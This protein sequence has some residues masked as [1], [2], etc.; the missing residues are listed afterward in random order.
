M[1]MEALGWLYAVALF[2]LPVGVSALFLADWLGVT[3]IVSNRV[4]GPGGER[5]PQC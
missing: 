1:M 2:G 4:S 3:R 5:R